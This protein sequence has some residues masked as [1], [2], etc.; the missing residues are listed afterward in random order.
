[1]WTLTQR[2]QTIENVTESSQTCLQHPN[3]SLIILCRAVHA[4]LQSGDYAALLAKDQLQ[5]VQ[6]AGIAFQVSEL[7]CHIRS[8]PGHG[9]ADCRCLL[10]VGA[11]RRGFRRA[12]SRLHPRSSCTPTQL[13]TTRHGRRHIQTESCGGRC[14]SSPE[15][16][17][18][19]LLTSRL[20][21]STCL[22]TD[23]SQPPSICMCCQP[24]AAICTSNL[25]DDDL[26]T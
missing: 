12:R 2:A 20:F 5:Q 8:Q 15:S 22:I 23:L 18:S 7:C 21:L 17:A 26:C 13:P 24:P 1:V 14:H 25:W 4:A 6:A 19:Q 9:V 3:Q 16:A 11:S 10:T